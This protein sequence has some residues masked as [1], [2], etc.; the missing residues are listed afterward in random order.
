[1]RRL[2]RAVRWWAL[3]AICIAGLLWG[4]AV[5]TGL[6]LSVALK[7]VTAASCAT[8]HYVGLAPA[9]RGQPGYWTHND[10]DDNG[11]SCDD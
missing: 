2:Y 7:H 4:L 6:P 3:A 11:M 10:A 5:H 8:A 9:S 1:M